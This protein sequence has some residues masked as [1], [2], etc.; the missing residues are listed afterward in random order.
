[1]TVSAELTENSAFVMLTDVSTAAY[2]P[3][4]EITDMAKIHTAEILFFI[5]FSP[6]VIDFYLLYT[7]IDFVPS[8][9]IIMNASS[10]IDTS[11]Y[12]AVSIFFFGTSTI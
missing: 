9:V 10:P 6:F 5:V 8:G 4:A 7:Y 2:V 11:P 12:V 3:T 1:M